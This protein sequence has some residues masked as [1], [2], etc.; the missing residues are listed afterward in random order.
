MQSTSIKKL[1]RLLVE[2]VK[3]GVLWKYNLNGVISKDF[4]DK[5]VKTG[6]TEV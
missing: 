2:T 3:L 4:C 1:T 6:I 5:F